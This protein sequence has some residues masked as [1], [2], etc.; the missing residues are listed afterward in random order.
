MT[1]VLLHAIYTTDPLH[2]IGA[3]LFFA[4]VAYLVGRRDG[5]ASLADALRRNDLARPL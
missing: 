5:A 3:L 4:F 2:I 1:A